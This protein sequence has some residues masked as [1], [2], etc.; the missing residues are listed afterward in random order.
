MDHAPGFELTRQP[1]AVTTTLPATA[2]S[3]T[4]TGLTSGTSYSYSVTALSP[5]GNSAAV[6]APPVMPATTVRTQDHDDLRGLGQ[7]HGHVDRPGQ[8]RQPD[9]RLSAAQRHEDPHRRS[10]HPQGDPQRA[11]KNTRL[12]VGLRAQNAQG[13]SRRPTR[14]SSPPRGDCGGLACTG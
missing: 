7:R 4:A 1:G 8:R 10:D 3:Y 9:H 6:S 5:N 13:W 2:H 12:R 11:G 14:P